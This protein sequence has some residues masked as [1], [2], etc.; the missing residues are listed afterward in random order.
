LGESAGELAAFCLRR[1]EPP[2]QV[3]RTAKLFQEY[4]QWLRA[5]G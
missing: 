2:R 1:R 3:R 5:A 4:Q